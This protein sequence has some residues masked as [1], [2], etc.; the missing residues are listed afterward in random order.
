MASSPKLRGAAGDDGQRRGAP[1]CRHL[2]QW[3][4]RNTRSGIKD[5]IRHHHHKGFRVERSHA[6]L[7]GVDVEGQVLSGREVPRQLVPVSSSAQSV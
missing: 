6:A 5:F 1:R 3:N 2:D 7:G 4:N